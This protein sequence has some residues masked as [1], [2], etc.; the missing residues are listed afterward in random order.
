[1]SL[2]K[3]IKN[4]SSKT[5]NNIKFKSHLEVMVYK[6]LLQ[7]GFKPLYEKKTFIIWKGI[8]PTVPC[9]TKVGKSF[10]LKQV[11]LQDITYT[12]DFILEF[13]NLYVI[14]EAKGF[15]NDVFP[16]KWKMF[17]KLIQGYKRKKIIIFE[18]FNKRQTLEA[19][20]II[21]NEIQDIP[22]KEECNTGQ[23]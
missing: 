8:K 17:R 2:N 4:A 10:G 5:F 23:V 20:N 19:I 15:V 13:P 14:I 16:L 12:P 9:Y 6:T 18:L 22:D 21:K 1:M 7:A 11:K 3:K